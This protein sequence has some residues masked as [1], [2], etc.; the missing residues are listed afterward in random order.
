MRIS[1]EPLLLSPDILGRERANR[2]PM[3]I[4]APITRVT[5]TGFFT[6][7]S[8]ICMGNQSTTLTI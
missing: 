5:K 2:N 1:Q 6:E 7:K 3:I 8:A 4:M